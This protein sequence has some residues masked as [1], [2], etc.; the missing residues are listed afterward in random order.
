M[1]TLRG[2]EVC[3][4]VRVC[5][6]VWCASVCL[7]IRVCASVCLCIRVCVH[8]SASV[9]VCLCLCVRLCPCVSVCPC[10]CGVSVYVWW[11]TFIHVMLPFDKYLQMF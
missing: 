8:V 4:F 11:V 9:S 10:V 5:A 3:V 1:L 7:C 6:C 2:F